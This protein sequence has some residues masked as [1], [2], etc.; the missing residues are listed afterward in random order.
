MVF[1]IWST[2]LHELTGERDLREKTERDRKREREGRGED[3]SG[4]GRLMYQLT[5]YM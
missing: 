3:F 5:D 1:C 2:G 4:R